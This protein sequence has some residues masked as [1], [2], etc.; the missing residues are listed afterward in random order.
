MLNKPI[1]LNLLLKS[2]IDAIKSEDNCC[3]FATWIILA[4]IL[5][6]PTLFVI[7]FLITTIIINT[8]T[9]VVIGSLHVTDII[10]NHE[11]TDYQLVFDLRLPVPSIYANLSAS[12]TWIAIIS[13]ASL[14]VI[15]SLICASYIIYSKTKQNYQKAI[16]SHSA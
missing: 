13:V 7:V 10:F 9:C 15:I 16:I 11:C 4:V 12:C 6:L 3:L 14:M 8:V 1:K 2:F 5:G